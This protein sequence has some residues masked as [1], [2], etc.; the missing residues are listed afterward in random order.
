MRMSP[1]A[2]EAKNNARDARLAA[3]GTAE[4]PL[5]YAAQPREIAVAK[6]QGAERK[7]RRD[8]ISAAEAKAHAE[9]V[10]AVQVFT[11][12]IATASASAESADVEE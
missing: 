5:L 8:A 2:R 11:G 9:D 3:K 7:A 1:A 4:Y 12:Q 6:Q 10:G